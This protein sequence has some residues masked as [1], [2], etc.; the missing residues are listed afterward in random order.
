[1]ARDKKADAGI[2]Y[3]VLEA[4][5]RPVVVQPD[6]HDVITAVDAVVGR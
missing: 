1:M 2:R 3:V 6:P 4:L 5:A